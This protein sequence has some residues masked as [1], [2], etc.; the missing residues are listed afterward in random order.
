MSS[1]YEK[2]WNDLKAY[3]DHEIAMW[4]SVEIMDEV[5]KDLLLQTLADLKDK[6]ETLE[7]F[8]Q[9]KLM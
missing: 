8:L 6:I 7:S 5:A 3:V 2:M 1:T 9:T 4:K